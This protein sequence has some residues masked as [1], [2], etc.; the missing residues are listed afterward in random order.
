MSRADVWSTEDEI[1][2]VRFMA[3]D[4]L[5]GD[6]AMPPTVEERIYRVKTW[7]STSYD[8]KPVSGVEFMKVRREADKLLAELVQ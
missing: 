1:K 5:R 6:A 4:K 3:S 8:R 7:I 2:A